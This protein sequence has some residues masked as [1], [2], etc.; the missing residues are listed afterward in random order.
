MGKRTRVRQ[1][2]AITT[3]AP[4]AAPSDEASATGRLI[5][6]LP[7][8]PFVDEPEEIDRFVV[9]ILPDGSIYFKGARKQI[10]AFLAACAEVGLEV[11][12]NQIALCG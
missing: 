5:P 4:Q 1:T 3:P 9:R 8:G 7:R 11:R 12:V 6:P 2:T 10:E